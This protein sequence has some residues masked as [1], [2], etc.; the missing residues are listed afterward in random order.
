MPMI[1]GA[2]G[3]VIDTGTKPVS[4]CDRMTI[5]KA[6]SGYQVKNRLLQ[7]DDIGYG[8]CVISTRFTNPD[9]YNRSPCPGLHRDQ[10]LNFHRTNNGVS[11]QASGINISRD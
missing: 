8:T 7:G 4:D 3:Y 2:G 6:H 1:Q 11:L 9:C 10:T 5:V